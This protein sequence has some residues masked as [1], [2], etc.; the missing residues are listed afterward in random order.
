MAYLMGLKN[1]MRGPEALEAQNHNALLEL[2]QDRDVQ[3]AIA[4][5]RCA[6]R[7]DEMGFNQGKG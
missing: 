1:G 5:A 4:K 3:L 6:E 7:I 2:T